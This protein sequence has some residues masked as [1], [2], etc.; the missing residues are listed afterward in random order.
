MNVG[1]GSLETLDSSDREPLVLDATAFYAG[2]PFSGVSRYHTT[3][4]VIREVS[5]RPLTRASIQGLIDAGRL[6]IRD[7]HP[8]FVTAVR[9]MAF[10]SGDL[11]RVSDAD[12][13]VVALGLELQDEGRTPMLL[14]DDYAVENLARHFE[15]KLGPVMT[16]GIS[17]VVKWVVYCPGC[18]KIFDDAR[19]NVCDV[20]G[21]KLKRRF[22]R[23]P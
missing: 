13:S 10:K 20:C 15:V 12:M 2:I 14:S 1:S 6:K 22:P 8:R 17:R 21:T 5:H 7:P 19:I 18:G 3:S 4:L 11:G 16:R 9:E 23:S